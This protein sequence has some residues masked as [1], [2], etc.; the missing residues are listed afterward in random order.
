MKG[1]LLVEV[2]VVTAV[3]DGGEGSY[4]GGHIKED[5]VMVGLAMV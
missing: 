1:T 4:C 5:V 2:G 3:V